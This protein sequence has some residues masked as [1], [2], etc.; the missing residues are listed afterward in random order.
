MVFSNLWK[1]GFY[2]T[3]GSKFGADFLAY[4]GD[5]VRYHAQSIVVC[6]KERGERQIERM[7][8]ASLVARCRLGTSVKKTVLFAFLSD[9]EH[10]VTVKYRALRWTGKL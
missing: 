3:D 4:P 5:P 1:R 8:E 7:S 2:L 10:D 6:L 9:D